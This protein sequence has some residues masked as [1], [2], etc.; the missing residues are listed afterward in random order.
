MAD[1]GG[2]FEA[3][4]RSLG[5]AQ[6]A[7]AGGTDVPATVAISEAQL[8]VKVIV[9]RREEGLDIQP[10]GTEVLAKGKVDPGLVST[11][12]LRFV[13]VATAEAPARRAGSDV[14]DEVRKRPDVQRVAKIVG[15]LRFEAQFVAGR[16][17]L[18]VARDAEGRVVREA[19]VDDDA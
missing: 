14:I 4:G 17:W 9:D 13:P 12:T 19:V 8:E 18:V 2:F 3:A 7:L 6:G 15:D 11:V 5:E 16:R 1:A 10:V